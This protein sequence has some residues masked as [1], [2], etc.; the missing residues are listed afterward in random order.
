MSHL[1]ERGAYKRA[2][3]F[4]ADGARADVFSDLLKR[5]DLPHLS[6]HCAERGGFRPITTVFPS[7]TGPAY[8]PYLT[9]CFPGT[10]NVPGIRW[11]DKAQYAKRPFGRDPYRSYVGFTTHRINRD[12]NPQI[13]TAFEMIPQ[14]YN[15]LNGVFRGA[16]FGHNFARFNRIWLLY[17]AHLTDS[18]RFID[19]KAAVYLK[20]A[21][22]EDF[23]FIFSVF[24]GID[25]YSHRSNPFEGA[26]L[27]EYRYLDRVFGQMMDSLKETGRADDTL[28]FLVS[29]HGLSETRAHFEIFEFL[30]NMGYKTFHYPRIHRKRCRAASMVSG[31]GMAN[32][33]LDIDKRPGRRLYREDLEAAPYRNLL[34]SLC[35]QEAVDLAACESQ[36]GRVHFFLKGS[37]GI[38]EEWGNE[39]RYSFS[40]KDP[41]GLFETPAIFDRDTALAM[42][43][44]TPHPDLFVQ[45]LQIFRSPRAGDLVLSAKSGFDFRAR[46]E[47]PKHSASHGALCREHMEI[48]CFAN[49]DLSSR[50]LRS[51]DIFPLFLEGLG[52]GIPDGIDGR[53]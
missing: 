37:E 35:A 21:V 46:Y 1:L 39:I 9:G 44:G 27:D 7:T 32:I 17:Y 43:E 30:E 40:G 49:I 33:Y 31:N 24:P 18:W 22:A 3:I 45:L 50:S 2:V 11:F 19:E 20:R 47:I 4:L 29:D 28:F 36:T 52:R 10:V 12:L 15:I 41:L 23:E 34:S 14:S 13:R 25:E 5:G 6:R 42:T 51:V 26:V 38:I 16:A 8:V 48:P 53:A